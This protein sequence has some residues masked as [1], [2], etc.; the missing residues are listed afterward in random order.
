MKRSC[1]ASLRCV[2]WVLAF[3]MGWSALTPRAYGA[4]V[5]STPVAAASAQPSDLARVQQALELKVVQQRLHDLGFSSGEVQ[6]RL[7]RASAEDLHQLAMQSD[8]LLAGG[9]GVI[10][11]LIIV[12]L[13][14]LILR[15]A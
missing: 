2:A 4:L 7:D 6:Q 1:S 5:G 13:V 10:T 9:D 12:L 11:I 3:V 15:I 8:Q 14:V